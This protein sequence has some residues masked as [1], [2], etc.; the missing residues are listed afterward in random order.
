MRL[1]AFPVR[2]RERRAS[3]MR[4][5]RAGS[6]SGKAA[7]GVARGAG[8][9]ARG[10]R[11][12]AALPARRDPTP[13]PLDHVDQRHEVRP[14]L[15]L[16]LY[17]A[18]LFFFSV[19]FST[20]SLP[21]SLGVP[22]RARPISPV[23]PFSPRPLGAGARPRLALVALRRPCRCRTR[24]TSPAACLCRR[25]ARNG[26]KSQGGPCSVR[27]GRPRPQAADWAPRGGPMRGRED[28]TMASI[29]LRP[30]GG[31][32][33]CLRRPRVLCAVESIPVAH[34]QRAPPSHHLPP[35]SARRPR[36][37]GRDQ[38]PRESARRVVDSRLDEPTSPAPPTFDRR[39][40][41]ARPR[42]ERAYPGAGAAV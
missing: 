14:N 21:L 41:F 11:A 32:V 16:R 29:E 17:L 3:A 40:S 5:P 35:S 38:A 28:G 34:R 9:R 26:M 10:R 27:A 30:S 25:D 37:A 12:P 22:P 2:A 19:R 42:C 7:G 8:A 15:F 31:R 24:T 1:P 6:E 4:P 39:H 13:R 18:V 36:Q 20:L 23:T 33:I